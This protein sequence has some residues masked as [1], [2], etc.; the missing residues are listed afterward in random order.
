LNRTSATVETEIGHTFQNG[1]SINSIRDAVNSGG[2]G[3]V[4][5]SREVAEGKKELGGKSSLRK[6]SNVTKL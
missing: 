5:F 3:S 6:M 4:V 2:G 1:T